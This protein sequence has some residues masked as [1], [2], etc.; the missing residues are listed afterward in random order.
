MVSTKKIR[1]VPAVRA[2]VKKWGNSAAI[3]IPVGVMAAARLHLEEAVDVREEDG[4]IV[5][6]PIR[7][8]TCDLTQL[9]SGITPENRH[10]EVDFGAAVG[11]EAF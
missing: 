4:R 6:E 1:G 11:H 7:P 2:I 9:L 10:A 8:P 5:I 3:R